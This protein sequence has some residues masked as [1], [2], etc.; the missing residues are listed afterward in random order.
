[1]EN[2]KYIILEENYRSNLVRVVNDHIEK[3]YEPF[4]DLLY[5]SG[6]EMGL[7]SS[8]DKYIQ[9]MILKEDEKT[10]TIL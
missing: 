4:G 7:N 2:K 6:H 1:M 10:K 8:S 9:A 3:G 5:K